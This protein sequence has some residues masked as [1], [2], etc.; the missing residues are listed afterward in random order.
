MTNLKR[1]LDIIWDETTFAGAV[2]QTIDRRYVARAFSSRGPGWGVYDIKE[3]RFLDDKEVKALT[4]EQI[5]EPLN[6][7]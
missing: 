5:R 6:L 2:G 4:P 3:A 1:N 7:N